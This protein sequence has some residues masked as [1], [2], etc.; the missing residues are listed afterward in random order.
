[1]TTVLT[2]DG[3]DIQNNI[4]VYTSRYLSLTDSD[5]TLSSEVLDTLFERVELIP[6][7]D[8]SGHCREAYGGDLTPSYG[9]T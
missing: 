2:N 9:Q 5:L 7:R 8:F 1:M 4:R 6:F 3:G